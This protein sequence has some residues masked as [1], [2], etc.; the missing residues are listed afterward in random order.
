MLL[1]RFRIVGHS[2]EPAIKNGENVLVSNIF[3]WFKKPEIG[4]IVAFR[5]TEQILIK[6]ITKI[7]AGEYFLTGDNQ[8]DSLDSR[9]LGLI[10][11][12]E[13]IGKVIYKI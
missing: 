4:D 12:K 6:R 13:I 2:M 7:S 9:K 3:Y 11:R 10:K 5:D 8:K 1:T